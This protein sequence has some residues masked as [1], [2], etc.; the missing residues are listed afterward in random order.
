MIKCS[1]AN[2]SMRMAVKLRGSVIE[3][4]LRRL[5]GAKPSDNNDEQWSYQRTDALVKGLLSY[6][7]KKARPKPGMGAI[8]MKPP[9]HTL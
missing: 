9:D 7:H 4:L 3:A 1:L 2:P 5:S 8:V 6:G